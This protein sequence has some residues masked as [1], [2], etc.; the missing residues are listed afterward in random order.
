[1]CGFCATPVHVAFANPEV[2][3]FLEAEGFK[4]AIRLPANQILNRG[5]G[6]DA[7]KNGQFAG[8]NVVRF[9]RNAGSTA[10]P[11]YGFRGTPPSAIVHTVSELIWGMSDKMQKT[12]VV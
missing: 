11:A 5:S 1:M 4:C 12:A 6:M 3:A 9:G 2:Y 7:R 8:S 10:Q